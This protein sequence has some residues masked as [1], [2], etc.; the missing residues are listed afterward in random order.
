MF[1]VIS[2][3]VSPDTAEQLDAICE[4]MHVDTYHIFQW[5]VQALVRMAS[6]MH[7]LTPDIQKLMAVLES[8]LRA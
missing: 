1:T 2:T 3:K 4:A 8:H 7:Q 5:F 6:P